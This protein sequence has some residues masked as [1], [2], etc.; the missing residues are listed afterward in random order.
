MWLWIS[1][2][3][4]ALLASALAWFV[5]RWFWRISQKQQL[6]LHQVTESFFNA[7]FLFV[8]SR[9][10]LSALLIA[11]LGL[12]GLFYSLGVPL[13]VVLLGV[14]ATVM[15][16]P[17][18]LR[19]FYRRRV[20]RFEKQFPDFLLGLASALRAGSSVRS[21][22][23]RVAQLSAAPLSQEMELFLK[24]QRMGLSLSQ[25]LLNLHQ[26]LN[27]EST[28]LFKSAL[29]VAGQSGGGLADLLENMAQTIS[30]RLYIEGRVRALTAQ[31]RLQAW[32]MVLLPFLVGVALY[33]LD[34]NLIAP[35]WQESSGQLLLALMLILESVGLWWVRRLVTISL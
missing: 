14:A 2:I 25:A 35:L 4:C 24:E 29:L 32:V 30:T 1:V 18:G 10:V 9:A 11:L 3:C 23:T 12:G 8:K 33:W 28:A 27:C 22:L 7:H 17:L 21:S 26:R 13:I 15:I 31:G 16:W 19:Y 20:Y 6:Y 34:P 5:P